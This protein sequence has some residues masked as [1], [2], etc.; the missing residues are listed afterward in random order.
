M[1]A[2]ISI[3]NTIHTFTALLKPHCA[4]LIVG[5]SVRREKPDVK[6]VELIVMPKPTLLPFL[7]G[8]VRDGAVSKALY[9]TGK[10]TTR[11]GT[12]YRGMVYAGVRFELFTCDA[13]NRGYQHWLR[14]GPGDANTYIMTTLSYRSAPFGAKDG[15]WWLGER[16]EKG[17][18][19]EFVPD[20]HAKLRIHEE[21]EMFTLLGL[22]FIEP[23]ARSEA[24]YRQL[25]SQRGH[26]FGDPAQF[27]PG[28]AQQRTFAE[29]SHE[30]SALAQMLAADDP[31]RNKQ[32]EPGSARSRYGEEREAFSVWYQHYCQQMV[33]YCRCQ[34]SACD[35][36]AERRRYASALLVWQARQKGGAG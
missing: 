3:L 26:T 7:D 36:D 16:I 24:L 18:K 25:M 15:Y 19:R 33:D 2:A 31:E 30:W 23:K 17:G 13:D 35:G 27:L 21:H 11:W 6:D 28:A 32:L 8:L 1:P 34:A 20:E 9:G 29:V 22:P 5:G 10:Q 14:T 12:S 4:E